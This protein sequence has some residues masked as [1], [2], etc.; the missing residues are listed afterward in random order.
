LNQTHADSGT[1]SESRLLSFG[2]NG[3]QAQV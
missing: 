1:P 2:I 3:G